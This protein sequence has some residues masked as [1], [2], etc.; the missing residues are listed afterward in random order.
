MGDFSRSTF[1]RVKHYVGVRLQQGV[2]LVDADWNELE[3]IR[4]YEVQAFLKWFVGDGVP[5]NN[6]GFRIAALAGGGVNT[7]RLTASAAGPGRSSVTVNVAASTAAA[8]LGFTTANQQASRRSAPARLTGDATQ[9]F[10]LTPGMTLVVSAEGA[11]PQTVTFNAESTAAQVVSAIN[12]ALTRVVASV[13]TGDDFVIIGGDGTPE[14][15]GRCLVD[16]RDAVHEG[17]LAYASQPLYANDALAAEWG[18]PVVAP[19]APPST[20][21]RVDL[22]YLDVWDREVTAAE[23]DSLVNPM[24]GVESSVRL[25]REWAVRVRPGSLAVPAPNDSDYLSE[26]SYLPLAQLTRQAGATAIPSST[27]ADLRARNLLVPPSTLVEDVLGTGP[28]TGGSAVDA[29]RAGYRR[30][31]N[32]PAISLRE[33][34][35]ALLAGQLPSTG[36]LPVSTAVGSDVIRRGFLAD[37]ANGLVAVWQSGR[38][39]GTT[40]IYAARIDLGRLDAGFSP[41][42][43]LTSTPG[44]HLEATAVALPTGELV[45]AYQNGSSGVPSTDLFMNR[46]TFGALVPGTE[47]KIAGSTSVADEN[48]LAVLAGDQVVFFSHQSPGTTTWRYQRYRWS[49]NTPV[50]DPT[51]LS[52]VVTGAV[53]D[54]HAA[55]TTTGQI[56]VAFTASTTVQVLR[57]TPSTNVIDVPKS[58][59]TTVPAD[60]AG[61]LDVFVLAISAGEA[62]AFWD[63]GAGVRMVSFSNGAWGEPVVVPSTDAADGQP[64]AVRDADGTI[65]LLTV[66]QT[67]DASNEVFLRRLNPVTNAWSVPQR[68]VSNLA[69]DQRPNP[70]L[71]PGQGIWVMWTSDRAGDNDLYAKRII[72]AI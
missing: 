48:P 64:A 38:V 65:Y 58:I 6:D 56:W 31:E 66:R 4:R 5:A 2:P 34:I 47:V 52:T 55:A 70:V 24:I 50:E 14:G 68:V 23:D 63:D 3:D 30:G 22:I 62:R 42:R 21:S 43:V 69:N 32:R 36:D 54:L 25:R 26:H 40:Q 27:L 8:V 28:L 72:T 9:P 41:A 10:V 59:T 17:R 61:V 7:I 20:G 46:G 49:E 51:Q 15:A 1:D 19:L 35:N 60:S 29:F 11:A 67:L 39:P 45:V 71:V 16:G 33:A 37:A 12:A 18:V 44:S 53:R 57:L 13:G